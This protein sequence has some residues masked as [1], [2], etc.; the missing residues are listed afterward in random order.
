MNSFV[1]KKDLQHLL[2]FYEFQIFG[3]P[4]YVRTSGASGTDFTFGMFGHV[5]R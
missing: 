2:F 4:G 5:F 1:L 3:T